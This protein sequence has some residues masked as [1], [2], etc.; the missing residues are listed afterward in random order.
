LVSVVNTQLK[1]FSYLNCINFE[2]LVHLHKKLN[3]QK[4]NLRLIGEQ[5]GTYMVSKNSEWSIIEFRKVG[6]IISSDAIIYLQG[7]KTSIQVSRVDSNNVATVTN[8][9]TLAHFTHFCYGGW[10]GNI[11][12][13]HIFSP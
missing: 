6:K 11:W 4:G 2:I 7:T 10:R 1:T 3:W 12:T 9:V 13:T 5:N 8:I